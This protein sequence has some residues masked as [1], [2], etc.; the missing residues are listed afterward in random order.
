MLPVFELATISARYVIDL[1][2]KGKAPIGRIFVEPGS[3]VRSYSP[4]SSMEQ[5]DWMTMASLRDSENFLFDDDEESGAFA[6]ITMPANWRIGFA[7]PDI[8]MCVKRPM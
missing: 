6:G 8:L 4:P 1:F 2:E 7:A 5:V 3:D